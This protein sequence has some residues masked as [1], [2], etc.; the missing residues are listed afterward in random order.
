MLSNL[1]LMCIFQAFKRAVQG[2]S[3]SAPFRAE[4]GRSRGR[5]ELRIAIPA[6]L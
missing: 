5:S 3:T 1:D 2:I 6:C 4:P